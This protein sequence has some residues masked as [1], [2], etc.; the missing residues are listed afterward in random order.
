MSETFSVDIPTLSGFERAMAAAPA[1]L[2]RE[3]DAAGRRIGFM[4][5][6]LSHRY[7]PRW[8]G[9][10]AASI[11][12]RT[13]AAGEG[14]TIFFGASAD[15]LEPVQGAYFT[16]GVDY[17]AD[18]I[19]YGSTFYM[20]TGFHGFHVIVGTIFLA[21]CFFRAR[22][23]HFKPQ[24]HFGFEAAAWYWHFVD[25]VWLFLFFCIYVFGSAGA[26]IAHH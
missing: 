10:L 19:V 5:E 7:V 14:V 3:L 23:G 2:A 17:V 20:A 9:N 26:P 11:Y 16:A 22:A 18:P 12:S 8:I 24:H 1:K 6:L 4:G 15:V 13:E 21:V 25:V